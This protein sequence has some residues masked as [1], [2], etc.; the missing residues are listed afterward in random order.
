MILELSDDLQ[1]NREMIQKISED[2]RV[3][4]EEVQ[5]LSRRIGDLTTQLTQ[6]QQRIATKDAAV[7]DSQAREGS[8]QR[9]I[10][11]LGKD[12]ELAVQEQDR[13][14][15]LLRASE[16][17]NAQLQQESVIQQ[18]ES[19]RNQRVAFQLW[20]RL[21]KVSMADHRLQR[22]SSLEVHHACHTQLLPCDHV[23]ACG[24]CVLRQTPQRRSVRCAGPSIMETLVGTDRG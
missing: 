18:N 5:Q 1:K 6:L 14:R 23:S 12:K 7:H 17:Q 10:E 4:N 21:R 9:Q 11:T 22:A 15:K 20:R 3:K 13:L 16:E 8:L 2:F 24:L 19:S